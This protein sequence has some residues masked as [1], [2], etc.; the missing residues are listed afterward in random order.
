MELTKSEKRKYALGCRRIEL[1]LHGYNPNRFWSI[2]LTTKALD[3]NSSKRFIK[4]VRKL[5]KWMRKDLRN[6]IEYIF[7]VGYTPINNLIHAHGLIRVNKVHYFKLYDGDLKSGRMYK[8]DRKLHS[9]HIDANRRALGDK[10]NEIHGAFIVDIQHYRESEV[11]N[12]YIVKHMLK[13]ISVNASM[14]SSFL[15]SKGWRK[16]VSKDLEYD[17]KRWWIELYDLSWLDKKGWNVYNDLIKGIMKGGDVYIE[18]SRGHF[19]VNSRGV[20]V[21]SEIYTMEV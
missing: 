16:K 2:H 5:I 6:D 9:P 3:D 7:G 21:E 20:V 8:G 4:D 17:F 19:L 11:L 10:W 13:D 14:R 1:G 18:D 12:E 15:V